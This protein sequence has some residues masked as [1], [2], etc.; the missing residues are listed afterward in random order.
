MAPKR[1]DHGVAG[2]SA[3]RGAIGHGHRGRGACAPRAARGHW[4]HG[5]SSRGSPVE[6]VDEGAL[7]HD[8]VLHICGL[9]SRQIS[10]PS[11]FAPLVSELGP[12]GLWLCA[13]GYPYYPLWVKIRIEGSAS[14]FLE[15]GWKVFAHQFNLRRGD[16]LCRRFDGEETLSMRPF[17]AGGN[18]LEPCWESSSESDSGGEDDSQGSSSDGSPR[19]RGITSSGSLNLPSE[20]GDSYSS[21]EEGAEDVKPVLKRARK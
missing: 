21:F 3:T 12:E 7:A 20:G 14:V 11:S 8:F 13:Q 16:S 5:G 1:H 9:I 17:D 15:A 6:A 19:S 10:L 18:R 4:G 2:A